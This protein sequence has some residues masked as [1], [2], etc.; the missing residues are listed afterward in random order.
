MSLSES[1]CVN[2]GGPP[3][4][5]DV[6]GIGV[7]ISFYLQTLFL[8]YLS[9]RSNTPEE[10]T[11]SLYTLIATNSAMAVTALTLGLKPRPEI[12]FHDA[13][14]VFYLL[15]L[16]WICV[17]F[18]MPSRKGFPALKCYSVF[19]SYLFFAFALTL[20]I[21]AKSFGNKPECNPNAVVVLFR[22]FPA[23]TSGRIVG[24]LIIVS[25]IAAYTFIT[26][27]DLTASQRKKF[28]L[29]Y[30]VFKFRK[31]TEKPDVEATAEGVKPPPTTI[32]NDNN[33]DFIELG[34][35]PQFKVQSQKYVI[36]IDW[37]LL[38][39]LIVVTILWSLSVMNTELLIVWSHF[40]SADDS[41]SSWQFGQL[42]PLFLVVIPFVNM[43][44]CFRK[45][46]GLR[47]VI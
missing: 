31:S 12:T 19:Q 25:I 36:P 21:K 28:N 18:S 1:T 24:W 30:K 15:Y 23:L 27:K 3:M 8:A 32:D 37:K 9:A 20:L 35:T 7:R 11:S 45:K 38:L 5:T 46:H 10:T 34:I 17:Y 4:N 26:V 41:R 14:V 33:M 13:I 40:E 42:L 22:P 29:S 43:V 16:S 39:K 47:P 2:R 44:S 6:S